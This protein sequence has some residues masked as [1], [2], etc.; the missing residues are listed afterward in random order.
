V[1]TVAGLGHESRFGS[2]AASPQVALNNTKAPGS[3]NRFQ[4]DD[5]VAGFGRLRS[6]SDLS[7]E[8]VCISDRGDD[9]QTPTMPGLRPS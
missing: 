8:T 9:V 5:R 1:E 4:V 6:R 2:A 7:S 3:A